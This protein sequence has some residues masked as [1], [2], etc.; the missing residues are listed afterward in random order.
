MFSSFSIFVTQCGSQR[1]IQALWKIAR[2][3][4]SARRAI[5]DANGLPA[6]L[7]SLSLHSGDRGVVVAVCGLLA[8]MNKNTAAKSAMSHDNPMQLLS[9]IGDT[10]EGSDA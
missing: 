6:V 8:R 1:C 7:K 4:N 2:D 5:G 10:H 9:V 3:R